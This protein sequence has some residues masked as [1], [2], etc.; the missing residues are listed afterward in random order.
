MY[1]AKITFSVGPVSFP[2][3]TLVPND[4]AAK[5]PKLVIQAEKNEVIPVVEKVKIG[6]SL[7]VTEKVKKSK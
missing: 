7:N 4:I 2:S 3:G 5:Y 1:K 6:E